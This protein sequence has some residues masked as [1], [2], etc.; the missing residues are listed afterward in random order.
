MSLTPGCKASSSDPVSPHPSPLAAGGAEARGVLLG[1]WQA[2]KLANKLTVLAWSSKL[3]RGRASAYLCVSNAPSSPP[4]VTVTQQPL[5]LWFIQSL[6]LIVL[7]INHLIPHPLWT[8]RHQPEGGNESAAPDAAC[9]Q[10]GAVGRGAPAG[11]SGAAR[12]RGFPARGS[13]PGLPRRAGRLRHGRYFAP[14]FSPTAGTKRSGRGRGSVP[15]AGVDARP[16]AAGGGRC[17]ASLRRAAPRPPPGG[18]RGERGRCAVLCCWGRAWGRELGRGGS[19]S[20]G[21]LICCHFHFILLYFT[22]CSA[23]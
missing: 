22:A 13:R 5:C 14:G 16:L 4:T 3:L 1:A 6:F 8:H 15:T 2:G 11:A 9:W 19:Y 18:C 20:W 23:D 17:R 7:I 10:R 21:V 12:P